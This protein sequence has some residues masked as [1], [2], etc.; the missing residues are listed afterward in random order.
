MFFIRYNWTLP[1]KAQFAIGT[2]LLVALS[3]AHSSSTQAE[4]FAAS[5]H[6]RCM[7]QRAS[8]T[9]EACAMHTIQLASHLHGMEFAD[10]VAEAF[11]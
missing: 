5:H 4:V 3:S 2:A 10:Q 11:R 1:L 8:A 7:Q 6:G 9:P